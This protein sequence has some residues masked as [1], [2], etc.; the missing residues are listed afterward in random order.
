M[1]LELNLLAVLN[2]LGAAQGLLLAL[3]LWAVGRGNRMANRILAALTLTISIFV[4]GAVLRTTG[5]LFVYPHLSWIHDPFP[6]LAGP[7]LYL[8]MRS[9]TSGSGGLARRDYLHFVPFAACALYL[10]PSYFLDAGAKLEQLNA[11]F[12]QPT[13]GRWYYVR[14]A[15]V[16]AHFLAYL[17]PVVWMLWTYARGAARPRTPRERA[18]LV[19]ARFLVYAC[20]TL[21]AAAV[22]RYA[23]DHTARTNLLVP[24]GISVSVYVLGYMAMREPEVLAAGAEETTPTTPAPPKYEKSSLTPER[25]DRYLKKLLGFMEAER[26]Y[27]DGELTLQ[28]LAALLSIPAQHLSQTVNGRLNQ[29]FV[30][31]VNTYRVE[32][33]KRK[34][35]DPALSHYSVLAIAEEVGFNSK[36]SFNAVF[37]KHT[38][39]TPSE[40]R[41]TAQ[42]REP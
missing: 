32:E 7:L 3:A 16:V 34:L 35:L 24:L 10:A 30:D 5:Y 14:S 12:W 41:N 20:L 29:S 4:C 31:F 28:K 37:K 40:F 18:V 26:P 27:A 1:K 23:F 33:A 2:L 42:Y 36:S 21:W 25:G 15:L 38:N 17:A 8:Y 9:L 39:M 13:M 6:F 11:E 19:R 22:L